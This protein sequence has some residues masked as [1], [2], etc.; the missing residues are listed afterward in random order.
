[1]CGLYDLNPT[2]LGQVDTIQTSS[3]NYGKQ[4]EH[5]N[6]VDVTINGRLPSGGLLQGGFNMGRTMT[7]TCDVDRQAGQ[8]EPDAAAHERRGRP[9]A[10]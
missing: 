10:S 8:P 1:M 5:Y 6:G 2:K 4:T 7:D 3:S 9:R